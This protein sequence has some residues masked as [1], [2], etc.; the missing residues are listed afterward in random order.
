MRRHERWRTSSAVILTML[1]VCRQTRH[2]PSL[3]ALIRHQARVVQKSVSIYR[4]P[5]GPSSLP[6]FHCVPCGEGFKSYTASATCHVSHCELNID[7]SY[8]AVRVI[9]V[10]CAQPVPLRRSTSVIARGGCV[11]FFLRTSV[12]TAHHSHGRTT[13][14]LYRCH[15]IRLSFLSV[16]DGSAP[17]TV[18]I[19]HVCSRA[20]GSI[21]EASLQDLPLPIP[22]GFTASFNGL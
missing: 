21:L 15:C 2:G 16:C 3:A 17:S 6:P 20:D 12:I 11:L 9:A 19:F 18:C 22:R 1:A 13:T 14:V 8:S 10:M 4:I 5:W 7:R